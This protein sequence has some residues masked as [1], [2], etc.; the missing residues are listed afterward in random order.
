MWKW[1]GKRPPFQL[2][3][4]QKKHVL[5][6]VADSLMPTP[7]ETLIEKGELPALSFL[8]AHGSM[9]ELTSV[10]PTMSVV[11]DAS[12][13]TGTY[14]DQHGVPGLVWFDR[15]RDR[16]VNYGD[17]AGN[18]V[19][20]GILR[21]AKDAVINLN[22]QH[23]NSRLPTIHEQLAA[24]NV[25]TA[26]VNLLAR[27]GDYR[28]DIRFPFN[29]LLGKQQ[30]TGP[31]ELKVGYLLRDGSPFPH[32]L[33][34]Y[35]YSNQKAVEMTLK[36]MAQPSPPRFIVTYLSAPDKVIHKKG[37]QAKQPLY[38][39]DRCVQNI[40]D[41]FPSWEEALKG[42]T[43]IVIGDHGQA[44]VKKDKK[45]A[46]IAVDD[47]LSSY[48][49]RGLGNSPPHADLAVAPNERMAFVYPLSD[50]VDLERLATEV[51]KDE[52]VDLI[53]YLKE[54]QHVTVCTE[55]GQLTFRPGGSVK[56]PYGQPWDIFGDPALLD[57]TKRGDT[58]QFGNYLDVFRQ[59]YGALNA[60]AHPV[61]IMTAKPGCEFQFQFSP[62]HVGGGSHGGISKQEMTVS[63]IV[64]GTTKK[65]AYN[66]LVDMKPYIID[67]LLRPS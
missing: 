32:P 28:H 25:T 18:I 10:F 20:Q 56:D 63:L 46:L 57:V 17:A 39:V 42:W 36:L 37:P 15:Q 26:S 45:T 11:N 52:R 34:K 53:A 22:E 7:L 23:L 30:I 43:I 12:L 5:L 38:D 41:C 60:Q 16:F 66:R 51:L 29:H 3:G 44:P 21:V 58:W 24:N 61:L 8:K 4:A 33:N 2:K 40:L 64:G 14:P 1:A 47:L 59:L 65:P 19:R 54:A 62:T 27:R 50:T 31:K 48:R 35:G 13:L 9:T 6:I 55:E 67:C 49:L